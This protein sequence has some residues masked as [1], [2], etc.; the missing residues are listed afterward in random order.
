MWYS[1]VER[2][3]PCAC[4]KQVCFDNCMLSIHYTV[5]LAYILLYL[6]NNYSRYPGILNS[7]SS[8]TVHENLLVTM[9]NFT[10]FL[11]QGIAVTHGLLVSTA[12]CSIQDGLISANISITGIEPSKLVF[13]IMNA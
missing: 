7:L 2:K 9:S 1:M 11:N 10:S 13:S 5:L 6:N 3:Q 8:I 4:Y 12:P